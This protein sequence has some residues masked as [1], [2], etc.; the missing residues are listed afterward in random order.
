M[1]WS[2]DSPEVN[3]WCGLIVVAQFVDTPRYQP[4]GWELN[5]RWGHWA[6]SFTLSFQ[7]HY[8]PGVNW[9]SNRNEYQGYLLGGIGGKCIQLTTLPPSCTAWLE[10]LEASTSQSPVGLSRPVM[11]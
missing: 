9:A 8:G 3:I 11:G 5:S 6:I 4:E 10:I 7:P 2:K 1:R